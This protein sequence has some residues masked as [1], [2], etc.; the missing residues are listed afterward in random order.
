MQQIGKK[1]G[2][3]TLI[4]ALITLAVLAILVAMAAPAL[5]D[6]FVKGRVK[7]AT[8]EVQGLI[9]QA[10]ADRVPYDSDIS[11]SMT[12]GN[13]ATW[14]IGYAKTADCDCTL[15]DPEAVGACS[16]EKVTGGDKVLHT[17][18]GAEFPDVSLAETFP[19]IGATFD[20]VRGTAS[21]AG[22]VQLSSGNWGL[23][24]V[25]SLTGR[26]RICGLATSTNSMGY[27]EC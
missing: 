5:N 22:T 27:P 12:P 16:F 1:P 19:G 21:P 7:R 26:I 13:S 18:M 14:C 24:V 2:G 20:E 11:I 6:F 9:A 17:V 4:E 10:K 25:V 23:G 15:T 8:V 3:F